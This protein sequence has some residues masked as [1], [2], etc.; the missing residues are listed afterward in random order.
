M[1]ADGVQRIF[2]LG[3]IAYRVS[4]KLLWDSK[5]MR[6]TNSGEA[7]KYVKPMFRPGWEQE[8]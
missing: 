8:L 7:N 4:G 1:T 6:F 2:V 5:N 3:A